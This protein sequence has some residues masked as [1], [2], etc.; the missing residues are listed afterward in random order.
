METETETEN[1]IIVASL[2]PFTTTALAHDTKSYYGSYL[3]LLGSRERAAD[4]ADL[5]GVGVDLEHVLRRLWDC[6]YAVVVWGQDRAVPFPLAFEP[7]AWNQE[8]GSEMKSLRFKLV[9]ML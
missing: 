5:P 2:L 3:P 9:A 4:R 7:R 1:E 6:V 8:E